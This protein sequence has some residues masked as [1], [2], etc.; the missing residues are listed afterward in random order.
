MS[1]QLSIVRRNWFSVVRT[2]IY[3]IIGFTGLERL[4][5]NLH[6]PTKIAMQ[7]AFKEEGLLFSKRSTYF[8]G[9][10]EK[11]KNATFL[12]LVCSNVI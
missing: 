7:L 11:L 5:R 6:T 10:T 12:R 4:A 8:S 9:F 3:K 2:G 1:R